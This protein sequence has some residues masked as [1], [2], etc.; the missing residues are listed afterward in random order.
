LYSFEINLK[1]DNGYG[2]DYS[3]SYI[4]L[5]RYFGVNHIHT[6]FIGNNGIEEGESTTRL[7]QLSYEQ[8]ELLKMGIEIFRS[9][10]TQG[11]SQFE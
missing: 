6:I 11:K 1:I 8:K 9:G 10:V 4:E 3:T 7:D 2:N 5:D